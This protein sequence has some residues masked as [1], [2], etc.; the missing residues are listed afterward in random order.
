MGDREKHRGGTDVDVASGCL[1]KHK[2]VKFDVVVTTVENVKIVGSCSDAEAENALVLAAKDRFSVTWADEAT[3][4]SGCWCALGA[5]V[6]VARQRDK[7][8]TLAD[9][10]C[11]PNSHA[12]GTVKYDL[13]KF[14]RECECMPRP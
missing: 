14:R 3:C 13:I 4:G 1:G 9:V 8:A 11:G 5:A 7:E 6:E 10:E 2:Q 12:T